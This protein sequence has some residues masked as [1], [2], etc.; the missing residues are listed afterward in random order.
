VGN[1]ACVIGLECAHDLEGLRHDPNDA[2][3]A[4]KEYAL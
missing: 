4:A 3:C 2:I 1:C